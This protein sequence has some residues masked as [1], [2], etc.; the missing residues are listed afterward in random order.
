MR[1]AGAVQVFLFMATA[2]WLPAQYDPA[3]RAGEEQAPS[4][5][6]AEAPYQ[7]LSLFASVMEMVREHYIDPEV[8]SYPELTEHALE[9][10]MSALDPH[11]EF[12]NPERYEEVRSET[13]GLFGGIGVYVGIQENRNLVVTMPVPGGAAF[14]AGLQPGDWVLKVDGEG[15]KGLSLSHLVQM[16]RGEPGEWIELTVYRPSIKETLEFRMQREIVNVPTIRN[17]GILRGGSRS[18]AKVGYIW[19]V[20]FG[21]QTLMEFDQA[22]D[23]LAGQGLDGLIL[24][25]RN[26][27]GGLLEAAVQLAGRFVEKDRVIVSTEGRADKGVIGYYRS[28]G[29]SHH[30]DLPLLVLV[31]RHSASGAE[32]VAGALRDFDRAV[33]VGERTYGKGSVQTIR[34]LEIG[35]GEQVGLRL[36]TAYYYTPSRQIIHEAGI[37]P[38]VQVPVSFEEERIIYRKQN[39]HMLAPDEQEELAAESDRQLERAVQLMNGMLIYRQTSQRLEASIPQRPADLPV[40]P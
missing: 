16:L 7:S 10:M 39:A 33:I 38:H 3:L 8:A 27:P 29:D 1:R 22:M 23:Q 37:Q 9:G 18:G 32:I 36:T 5:E 2:A 35:R 14:R 4:T 6:R 26:N 15:V 19:V 13:S 24:D 25:L 17:A 40:G 31:N 34:S 11:C 30:L 28:K 20:Q 21:D 12:L